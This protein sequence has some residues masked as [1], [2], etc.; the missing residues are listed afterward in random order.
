MSDSG[1]IMRSLLRVLPEKAEARDELVAL[2]AVAAGVISSTDPEGRA[3]L[4]ET[5]CA[6]LRRNVAIDLN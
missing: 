2:G 6:T 4:V 3:A 5:F 1:K